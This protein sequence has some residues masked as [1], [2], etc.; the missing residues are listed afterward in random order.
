MIERE[1]ERETNWSPGLS[2]VQ[3][4]WDCW[5]CSTDKGQFSTTHFPVDASMKWKIRNR[6]IVSRFSDRPF[7]FPSSPIFEACF[8]AASSADYIKARESAMWAKLSFG[9]YLSFYTSLCEWL[10]A[11]LLQWN[12]RNMNDKNQLRF[13]WLRDRIITTKEGLRWPLWGTSPINQRLL[14][15]H[16]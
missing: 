14:L 15:H 16:R 6:K 2:E 10:A 5:I 13:L 1:R 9:R 12:V 7:V 3:E 8:A 4:R 11:H